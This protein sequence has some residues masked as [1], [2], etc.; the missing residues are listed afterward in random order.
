MGLKNQKKTRYW[1]AKMFI[2]SFMLFTAYFSYSHAQDLAKLGFHDY[3]RI[4]LVTAK[5]IGAIVLLL[6]ITPVRVKQWVYAVFF[7]DMISAL[8][9]Q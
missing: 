1:V 6:P 9:A 5:I 3:F 7:V 2:S 8:I 4:E